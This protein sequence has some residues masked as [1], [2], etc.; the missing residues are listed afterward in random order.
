MNIL[1]LIKSKDIRDFYK[2]IN[3][4]S[5]LYFMNKIQ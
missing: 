2:R 4:S 5:L 3:F 1:D